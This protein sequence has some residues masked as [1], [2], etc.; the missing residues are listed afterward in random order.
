MGLGGNLIDY[1]KNDEEDRERNEMWKVGF[2]RKRIF[3]KFVVF[4]FSLLRILYYFYVE[5]FRN[6][7]YIYKGSGCFLL[8]K[9][10]LVYIK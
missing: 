9:L 4:F 3:V 6:I 2:E 10:V 5:S 8:L 1:K 7:I